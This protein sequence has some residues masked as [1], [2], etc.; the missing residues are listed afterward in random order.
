MGKD[1][2]ESLLA[3]Q[4][5][6]AREQNAI[7]ERFPDWKDDAPDPEALE[8]EARSKTTEA[9]GALRLVEEANRAAEE[10]YRKTERDLDR[11]R[12]QRDS[13]E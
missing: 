10:R 11:E 4:E 7:M 12:Q 9:A 13:L 6:L 5:G 3:A 2:L 1:S 8:S